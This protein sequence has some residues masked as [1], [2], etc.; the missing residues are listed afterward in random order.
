MFA[1]YIALLDTED[2]KEK[3]DYIYTKYK[4]FMYYVAYG[5]LK[6][7]FSAEDAVHETFLDLLRIIDDIR[8]SNDRELMHFLKVIT[9]H[10]AVDSARKSNKSKKADVEMEVDFNNREP[11]N[12]ETIAIDNINYKNMLQKI[13]CMDEKYKTPF[14]LKAQ[15][16]KVRE[17]AEFLDI[18]QENVKVRLHRA[19]KIILSVMEES[20]NG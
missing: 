11:E 14:L 3:F 7:H 5:V 4:G 2:Q 6:D 15:G 10:K 18:S 20:S 17:I 19:R 8:V 13:L 12:A 9:Y 16:Y 1:F